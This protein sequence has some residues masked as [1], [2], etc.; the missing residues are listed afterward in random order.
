MC[1]MCVLCVT[2]VCYVIYVLCVLCVCYV[3]VMCVMCVLCVTCVCYVI[4]VLYVLCVC[5]VL[6]VTCVCNVFCVCVLCVTC[7]CQGGGLPA[8]LGSP[9]PT[10][11]A[12]I[13]SAL[14]AC[15]GEETVCEGMTGEKT[16]QSISQPQSNR[17][18]QL[19]LA[20][21]SLHHHST[22]TPPSLHRSP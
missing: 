19:K 5:N 4:C 18:D 7:V 2:C 20:K 16:N 21:L 22:I 11:V 15:D 6:C 13:T 17:E 10:H 1:V 9:A 3:C 12:H 8:S 14:C